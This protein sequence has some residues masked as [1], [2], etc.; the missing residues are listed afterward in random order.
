MTD[1]YQ[2]FEIDGEAGPNI[3]DGMMAKRKDSREKSSSIYA[4][5]SHAPELDEKIRS[6][7]FG[8][9]KY[10]SVK[11]KE[12]PRTN[13]VQVDKPEDTQQR[14]LEHSVLLNEKQTSPTQVQ[15]ADETSLD[16]RYRDELKEFIEQRAQRRREY[17][18]KK[19][20][21]QLGEFWEQRAQARRE[22]RAEKSRR[23]DR[24]APDQHGIQ[25]SSSP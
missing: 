23:E 19:L 22:Y 4:D 25:R 9:V 17:H 11:R 24:T 18:E 16:S 13:V 15:S 20:Q 5:D 21:A 3:S 10:D 1:G 14:R 2:P 6:T 7:Q 8:V 12:F